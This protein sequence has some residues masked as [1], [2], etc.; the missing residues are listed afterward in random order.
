[1]NRT[2]A[3]AATAAVAHQFRTYIDAGYSAPELVENWDFPDTPVRWAVVWEDGPDDWASRAQVGGQDETLSIEFGRRFDTPPAKVAA[4]S[5]TP[6][7]Q[8]P[9]GVQAQPVYSYAVAL[10]DE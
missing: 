2:Q 3:L 9:R 10:Y 5:R 7:G 6:Q 1:M 4:S 8:W